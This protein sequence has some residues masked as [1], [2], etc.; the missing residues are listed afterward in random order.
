MRPESFKTLEA[1]DIVR[2]Q[3]GG[4]TAV[5]TAN[6]GG[7]VTAVMTYDLTNPDE[8][9]LVVKQG[10]Q[11]NDRGNH[12]SWLFDATRVVLE[13]MGYEPDFR[14]PYLARS[15]AD[16]KDRLIEVSID[17]GDGKGWD[18]KMVADHHAKL[19]GQI[20]QQAGYDPSF[21]NKA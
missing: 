3:I 20:A 1:G 7:R 18:P 4:N 17:I 15:I 6:Y 11:V 19:C 16:L 14:S 12:L 13:G 5:V 8:W 21:W 10:K 9:E 2:S